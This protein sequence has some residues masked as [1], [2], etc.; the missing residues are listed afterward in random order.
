MA[1]TVKRRGENMGGYGRGLAVESHQVVRGQD[2][3]DRWPTADAGVWSVPVVVMQPAG[4]LIAPMMRGRIRTRVG[5]FAEG[6]LDESLRLTVRA[7]V[8][9]SSGSSD[10]SL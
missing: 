4:E 1:T 7:R 10:A 3:S 6:G 9:V 5:P 8:V 2:P